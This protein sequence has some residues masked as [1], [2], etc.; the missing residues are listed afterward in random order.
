MR[1]G[2]PLQ[3]RPPLT[4]STAFHDLSQL[5][6]D[7][8]ALSYAFLSPIFDSISKTGYEAAFD[9]KDL[10]HSVPRSAV[11]LVALGGKHPR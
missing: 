3:A 2:V 6:H 1:P 10:A 5:Q 8:G 4:I 9:H 11:P 7:Y